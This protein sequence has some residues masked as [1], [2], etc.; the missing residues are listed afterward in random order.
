M[1][2]SMFF[3]LIYMVPELQAFEH[4]MANS[5][6]ISCFNKTGDGMTTPTSRVAMVE[7]TL[8]TQPHSDPAANLH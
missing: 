3:I 1:Y 6:K 2:I 8:H 4:C 7:K 5:I